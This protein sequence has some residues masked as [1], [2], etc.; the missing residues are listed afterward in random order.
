LLVE[1]LKQMGISYT[2]TFTI[3][4]LLQNLQSSTTQYDVLMFD[5]N[6]ISSDGL[7]K[8]VRKFNQSIPVVCLTDDSVS[9]GEYSQ[10]YGS[11]EVILNPPTSNY[12]F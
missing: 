6:L 10:S 2:E 11:N 7:T 12:L 5:G 9:Q 1:L 8:H 3:Q 4:S